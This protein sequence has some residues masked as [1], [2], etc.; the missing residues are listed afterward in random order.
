MAVPARIIWY[1][2]THG[3]YQVISSTGKRAIA[4]NPKPINQA[5]EDSDEEADEKQS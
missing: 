4:K 3:T 2:K 5:N 1:T